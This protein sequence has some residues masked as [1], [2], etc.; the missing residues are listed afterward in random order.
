LHLSQN[1]LAPNVLRHGAI[2]FFRIERSGELIAEER[3]DG[4]PAISLTP[5]TYD[6]HMWVR[7]CAENCSFLSRPEQQCLASF[8]VT[9]GQVLY[10]ERV[11]QGATCTIQFRRP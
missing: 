11:M 2:S 8:T 3:L 5:G 9:A 4:S 1:G 6:L 7:P 10:A